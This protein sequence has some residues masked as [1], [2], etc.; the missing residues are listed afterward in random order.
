MNILGIIYIFTGFLFLLIPI[1]FI[2]LGRPKDFIRAALILVIG[3]YCSF[4]TRD[5][6]NTF[7]VFLLINTLLIAI[8]VF[9]ISLYRWNQLSD[10]EKE[11]M[12]TFSELKKNMFKFFT[13]INIAKNKLNNFKMF[14][15]KNNKVTKKWVRSMDSA[16]ITTSDDEKSNSFSMP[17]QPA[18]PSQKNLIDVKRNL[19]QGQQIK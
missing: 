6:D 15:F 9:D 19:T 18:D 3:L 12:R 14:N 5:F 11:K 4:E 13:S 10:I 7:K 16:S 1:I 17:A 8:L 2:E